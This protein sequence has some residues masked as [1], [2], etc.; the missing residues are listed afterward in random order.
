MASRRSSNTGLQKLQLACAPV[1]SASSDRWLG[2]GFLDGVGGLH[3][4]LDLL[5]VTL[6]G[7]IFFENNQAAAR[8]VEAAWPEARNLGDLN[9]IRSHALLSKDCAKSLHAWIAFTSARAWPLPGSGS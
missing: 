6:A 5:G 9:L 7:Y 1:A 3:R 8:D 2:F 4:A